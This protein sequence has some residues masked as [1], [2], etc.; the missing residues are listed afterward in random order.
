MK[1]AS[2]EQDD[3]ANKNTNGSYDLIVIG[4]GFGGVAAALAA[5]DAGLS[6]VLTEEYEWI[7]G[8]VTSQALCALDELSYPCGEYTGFNKSY[9]RFRDLV[10]E[11]YRSNYKLSDL[12]EN[13][14]YLN[15]GNAIVSS[16]CGEPTA[17]KWA[18]QTMLKN[19]LESGR[20][21]ILKPYRPLA[22]I[23]NSS[24]IEEVS[25]VHV[26][27]PDDI[28]TL[29]GRY[30]LEAT[31][32]GDLYPLAQIPCRTGAE[33]K[34][35]TGE[36]HA[37]DTPDPDAVQGFTYCFVVEYDPG[38][39]HIIKKPDFYEET[40][41]RVGFRY[42]GI[43]ENGK[44][45]AN[46]IEWDVPYKR[47][48]WAYRRLID[49]RNFD[50]FDMPN[51]IAVINVDSNDYHEKHLLG[52]SLHDQAVILEEAKNLSRC[53][54]YWLQTEA[55][56]DDGGYGYHELKPRPDL[57]GADDGLAMAPYIREGRRLK[58]LTTVV[59][60]DILYEE[61]APAR[62][63][64][65]RDSVGLGCYFID[66]H[67]STNN[68]KG[69]WL[70]SRPYQIPLGTLLTDAC[71]NLIAAGKNIGVTHVTNGCYRLHPQEWAIG[72]AAGVLAAFCI[73]KNLKP[74]QVHGQE[75]LLRNFQRRL[76]ARG[77]PL[78]WYTDVNTSTPGF[79]E[80]QLLAVSGYWPGERD[81]IKFHPDGQI[82]KSNLTE[83]EFG[84]VGRAYRRFIN[85]GIDVSDIQLSSAWDQ[86]ARRADAAYQLG[87]RL[88]KRDRL[89]LSD[90]ENL[91]NNRKNKK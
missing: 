5:T 20:L 48:F 19:A 23:K 32:L 3:I 77:I 28:I 91:A 33:A 35:E 71:E 11:Y 53:Y 61:N 56:R 24:V 41:D 84:N 34:E 68:R 39:N 89:D 52:K 85:D 45:M 65:F 7:G 66:L 78:Y 54:L 14:L 13:T 29:R 6:V 62:A 76:V 26:D 16:L 59:A 10:R 1:N 75:K 8:Q 12:A 25:V 81:H 18:I 88:E 27:N 70:R 49:K 43:C 31:E 50:D 86:G 90:R 47:P 17:A 36:Q 58:A 22:C 69:H 82:A 44:F 55:P 9:Y 72:E 63:K 74:Y 80:I 42:T 46:S 87:K 83:G 37:L 73:K 51:D 64:E 15:P 79:K 4:G 38:G 2:K 40:R 60:Q 57:T 67:T 30:F 21:Q